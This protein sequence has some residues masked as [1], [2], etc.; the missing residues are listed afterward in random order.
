MVA[1]AG[2]SNV[3]KSSLLNRLVGA[4]GLAR[5]SRTPGR[6]RQVNYFLVDECL[7]LMDLPGY[8]YARVPTRTR[9]GWGPLSEA[10]LSKSGGPA[11][12]LL[13]VDG[14]RPATELDM[15]MA[16]WLAARGLAW[17]PVLTKTDKL[18][19]GERAAALKAAGRLGAPRPAMVTS[20]RTGEGIAGLWKEIEKEARPRPG[21]L[22]SIGRT[23]RA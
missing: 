21:D 19:A 2:R 22:K 8:G 6:T 7:V 4:R 17:V 18:A 23:D 5:V 9:A 15:M 10:A 16:S 20:A 11:L 3:G 14:R 1:L 12:T 13:L